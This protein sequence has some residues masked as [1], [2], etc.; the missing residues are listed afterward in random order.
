MGK[1]I[2]IVEDEFIVADD[3]Q[4]TL[5]IAGYYV[6]GIAASVA[7]AREMITKNGPELV[8]LD[9]H[10]KGKVSGIELAKE[11]KEQSIAFVYLSANS[12]QKILEEAKATDPYGFLVKP[13][14]EKD[15]LITLDIAFY[16]HEH[17]LEVRWRKEVQLQKELSSIQQESGKWAQKMIKTAKA[18][19]P[20][21]P[22]ECLAGRIKNKEAEYFSGFA[23]LRIGFEEYQTIGLHELAIIS[24]K[25]EEDITAILTGLPQ[26]THAG[27]YNGE[28]FKQTLSGNPMRALFAKTFDFFSNL[29]FPVS[30]SDGY[31]F[32]LCFF[33]SATQG[34][35]AEHIDWLFRLQP[36]LSAILN[37]ISVADKTVAV[38][39]K[40]GEKNDKKGIQTT[41][42]N[43]MIGNSPALLNV[44][45]M[46]TQVAPLDTSV[47]ILGES[48]TGKERIADYIHR[49]S[50]RQGKPLI[51]IN[52]AAMPPTLIESELFG[53]ERG[54]FTGALEKRTGKFEMAEGGTIFLDEIGEMPVELQVKLLRV[55]QEREIERVGGKQPVKV[56]VR[57]IAA[58]NRNLESE[59]AAGRFRLDLYYRLNVFPVTVPPLRERKEDI[60]KL[61][62]FFAENFCK[63]F[64]KAFAGISPQMLAEL[65]AYDYPGNIRELENI[66]EKAVILNDG[67][68]RLSLRQSLSN[69][70]NIANLPNKNDSGN[71]DIKT[72][73]DIR[74]VQRE[75]EIAHISSVLRKTRGRI[76][77]RDGAAEM[78]NEKPTTL[79]SRM[80]KLGIKKEDFQ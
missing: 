58:T 43:G 9:I 21:I 57:V 76:R 19:Q 53:H 49:I 36:Q 80:M 32:S 38:A 45:D 37:S 47:L 11:L 61:A 42:A 31:L 71:N 15:L 59:I 30:S 56:N 23:F 69:K 60:E 64:N 33:R 6:C 48:G 8:L 73:E 12:N 55:L 16:R 14:R 62:Y 75:T 4:L 25:N 63:K 26:E 28:E 74:R 54:A 5:Q 29:E 39:M 18:L 51:K 35:T 17:S 50:S 7:E 13:F 68:S 10:L 65:E 24:G 66:M 67:S 2:L 44:L 78:L 72:I 3:L 41:S 40:Y 70:A 27:F 46:V 20:Y 77:G 79:E 34:Y 1:K 22:F 52:C